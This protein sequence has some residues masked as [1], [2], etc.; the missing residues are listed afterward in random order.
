M[1]AADYLGESRMRENLTSGSGRGRWRRSD[2][3]GHL[4]VPG[5]WMEDATMMAWSGPSRAALATAPA[6]YFTLLGP[7]LC[8]RVAALPITGDGKW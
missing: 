2:L 4:R 7:V 6:P 8:G 1:L 5:R 3:L